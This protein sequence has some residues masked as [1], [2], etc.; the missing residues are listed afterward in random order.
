MAIT[1]F[2][3][4]HITIDVG[5]P[6]YGY[7]VVEFHSDD[8][9]RWGKDRECTLR[10]RKMWQALESL[11][12]LACAPSVDQPRL[13]DVVGLWKM[14][15]ALARMML[16]QFQTAVLYAAAGSDVAERLTDDAEAHHVLCLR[17]HEGSVYSSHTTVSK[18][19]RQ[20]G[21]QPF[22]Y[23]GNWDQAQETAASDRRWAELMAQP[24]GV[25]ADAAGQPE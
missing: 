21:H 3:G 25:P 15:S 24:V 5:D 11:T 17:C 9:D 8:P 4:D 1:C 22:G 18:D 6:G 2:V 13:M 23:A 10:G 19:C 14:T 20:Y 12:Q 7:V 16:P